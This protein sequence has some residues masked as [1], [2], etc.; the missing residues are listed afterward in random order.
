MI[1]GDSI[2]AAPG[3]YKKYLLAS[4]KG[5][6]YTNFEFVGEYTDDC[7]AGVKHSA[8]SCATAEQY[9]QPT[10]RMPNCAQ[11]KTFPGMSTLVA[12]HTPDLVMIQLGVNDVW[13]GKSV[14]AIL[15]SY[16]KLVQQARAQNPKVVLVVAQI[17]KIA[18]SCKPGDPVTILAES[19][20]Q[21]VPAWAKGLG[22][23]ASPVFTADLW[24]NS[25]WSR[26][27]AGDCVHPSDVVGSARMGTNWYNALKGILKRD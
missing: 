3:C 14:A 10:F 24:T 19:L 4:L 18:P 23:A 26:V 17:H 20:V 16:E 11:D 6:G 5:N 12:T 21:A 2:T 7:G 27:E 15:A 9:T 13:G 22:T 25:D 8:V 1:V